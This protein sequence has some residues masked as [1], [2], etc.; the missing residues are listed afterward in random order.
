VDLAVYV[1][2]LA[3][4]FKYHTYLLLFFVFQGLTDITMLRY[5]RHLQYINIANNNISC[6]SPLI[7]LPYLIYLN[8]SHNQIERL[9]NFTPSWYLTYVNLS[10]NHMTDLGDLKSCWSIVRLNLSHNILEKISGLENL[11]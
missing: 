9:S 10:Y 2:G 1:I 11:K 5:H 7:D 6:L 4:I 3:I 8:A